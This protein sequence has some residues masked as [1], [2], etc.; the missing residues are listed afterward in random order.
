LIAS[1][2]SLAPAAAGCVKHALNVVLLGLAAAAAMAG[3]WG[4]LVRLG[5][6]IAGSSLADMHG[7]LM[8]CGLFG[9]VISLERA[10]ALERRWAFAA[11]T[12]FG[13][14]GICIL[15]GA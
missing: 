7:P 11:P 8:V 3:L 13:S 12:A 4:G 14:G 15:I 1:P 10:V 2:R 9:T 5:L 6:P